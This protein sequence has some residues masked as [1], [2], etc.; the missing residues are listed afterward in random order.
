[1]SSTKGAK[2]LVIIAAYAEEKLNGS[3]IGMLKPA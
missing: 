1:M 2:E 3:K